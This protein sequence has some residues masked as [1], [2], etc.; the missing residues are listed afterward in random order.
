MADGKRNLTG[1]P[2]LEESHGEGQ[3][4]AVWNL[5]GTDSSSGAAV[6]MSRLCGAVREGGSFRRCVIIG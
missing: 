3:G 2:K 4:E 1:F 6:M 5:V